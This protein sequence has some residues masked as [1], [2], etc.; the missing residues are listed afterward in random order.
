MNI[1][2]LILTPFPTFPHGGRSATNPFPLGGNRKGGEE[3]DNTFSQP[4]TI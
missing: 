1:M 3:P 4:S 2:F